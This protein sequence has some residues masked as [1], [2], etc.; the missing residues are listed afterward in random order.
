MHTHTHTHTHTYIYIYCK[1]GTLKEQW[2][3][4]TLDTEENVINQIYIY[5]YITRNALQYL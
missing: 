5:I 2:D 4:A 3:V 1:A